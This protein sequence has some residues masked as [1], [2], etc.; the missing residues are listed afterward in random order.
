MDMFMDKLAQ[1]LTAQEIIKANTAADTEELNR[2]KNQ[3]Q[4]YNDCL[5]KLGKLLE[6]A[7]GRIQA[8]PVE[9]ERISHLVEEGIGR[10]RAVQ[11]DNST[12]E[13][14]PI[15]LTQQLEELRD[16][17]EKELSERAEQDGVRMEDKWNM[18]NDSVHKE[19]VKVYRNVQSVVVE[20]NRKQEA[21]VKAQTGRLKAVLGISIAALVISLAGAAMQLLNLLNIKFF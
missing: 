10:I 7:E 18:L 11:L 6:E 4:E 15:I 1:K 16:A 20:E 3:L 17:L 13:Q 19:C 14:I 21:A 2:L 12:L 9:A 5:E 8:P